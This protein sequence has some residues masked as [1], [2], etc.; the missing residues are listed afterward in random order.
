MGQAASACTGALPARSRRS[1]K[2]PGRQQIAAA[3]S[4]NPSLL[5]SQG[6]AYPDAVALIKAKGAKT[7]KGR[8][9]DVLALEVSQPLREFVVPGSKN[10]RG[11]VFRVPQHLQLVRRIG[12]GAYACVASFTDQRTGECMA[13]KKISSAFDDLI[14]GKRVLREV[15]IL[16]QLDHENIIRIRDLFPPEVADFEDVYIA[17]DLMESDLE[18][19]IMSKQKLEEL[20]HQVFVYQILRGVVYLHDLSITHRDL[21]PAN[22]LV[23]QNCDVKI[24]DFNLARVMHQKADAP[25]LN[26]TDV[27]VTRWYRAPE[28]SL[29]QSTYTAAIDLWSIGL[30]LCEVIMRK[31]LAPGKDDHSQIRSIVAAFGY[32]T[33][34]E[35][36]WLP[37]NGYGRHFLAG[38]PKTPKPSW[39]SILPI[40]SEAAREAAAAMV[41]FH[42]AARASAKGAMELRYFS[43]LRAED[44]QKY[45]D[46]VRTPSG[47]IDWSFD[48]FE[49]TKKN[50]QVRLLA[51]CA[52]FHPEIL[53]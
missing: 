23:N 18:K 25:C 44:K 7:G 27:V 53:V 22:I 31:P 4:A 28:V 43:K 34:E 15:R 32:P 46:V 17:T 3:E 41:K 47:P 38:C 13:V 42:P 12:S 36:T 16:R 19:V 40:A 30:I 6:P 24:C 2:S 50:L 1:S 20:H 49:P 37:D 10:S 39:Q 29:M 26:L 45:G 9:A 52:H 8:E 21:K 5:R 33:S 51:E 48:D 11:T 14:D 35:L